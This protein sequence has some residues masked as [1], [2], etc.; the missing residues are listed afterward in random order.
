[1]VLWKIGNF[2]PRSR[3]GNDQIV[4][5]KKQPVEHFNPRSRVGNDRLSMSVTTHFC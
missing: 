3:V 2:N 4:R 1:M 5:V